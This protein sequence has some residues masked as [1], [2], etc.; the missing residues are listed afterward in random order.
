MPSF[1]F[2]PNVKFQYIIIF[3]ADCFIYWNYTIQSIQSTCFFYFDKV[4]II[5]FK[6][7]NIRFCIISQYN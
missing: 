4:I 3:I 6:S 7:M 1:T 2:R 5:C